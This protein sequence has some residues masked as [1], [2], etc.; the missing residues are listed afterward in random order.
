[1]ILLHAH[2]VIPNPLSRCAVHDEFLD[3][4]VATEGHCDWS[5]SDTEGEAVVA[6]FRTGVLA[7]AV[8]S[9]PPENEDEE[10]CFGG[11]SQ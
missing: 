6:E 2:C 3:V 8:H 11:R 7:S 1:M 5:I 10:G 9:G 4:L